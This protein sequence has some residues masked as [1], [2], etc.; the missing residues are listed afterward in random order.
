MELLAPAGDLERAKV[1]LLYGADAVYLGGTKFSLRARA[2][3]FTLEDIGDIVL[4]AH[5]RG[6]KVYVTTNIVAHDED[7]SE[8]DDYL[9]A[10]D[11]LGVDAI[12]ASSPI[13]IDRA[14]KTTSLDIHLSTQVSVANAEGVLFWASLGVT[15]VVLARECSMEEISSIAHQVSTELE[16]FVHGGMCVSYSGRC[17]LSNLLSARDANR[18]GCAHSCRWNYT[19]LHEHQP[20]SDHPDFQMASTDL[21]GI[22]QVPELMRAGVASLKIEGRMKSVHYVATVVDAYRRRIDDTFAGIIRDDSEYDQW[23][24]RAE[25]RP[26][27]AGFLSDTKADKR[28]IYH[29]RSEAVTQEYLGIVR[30]AE[31]QG[32][33]LEVRNHFRVGDTVE[34]FSP[35]KDRYEMQVSSLQDELGNE[36]DVARHPKQLLFIPCQH[37][38]S[39][40]DMLRKVF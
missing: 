36:L 38:V 4:F 20:V 6:K 40:Y 13:I 32:F 9:H 16:V 17:T 34:I 10:L 8:L 30:Q 31:E 3:N 39:P 7:L 24:S 33:W 37:P 2:S 11:S 14:S 19:L 12:I 21:N 1:A 28:Q 18:G 23:I 29:L 15:R 26:T 35:G 27:S 25:N 5:E 22:H